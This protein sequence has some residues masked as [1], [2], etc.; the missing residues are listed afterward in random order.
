[1]SLCKA[2]VKSTGRTCSNKAVLNSDF[3]G[4]HKNRTSLDDLPP[5]IFDIIGRSLDV[6]D[7][8]NLKKVNKTIAYNSSVIKSIVPLFT[9]G[10]QNKDYLFELLADKMVTVKKLVIKDF[11]VTLFR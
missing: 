8:F 11:S 2:E 4:V 10:S 7:V 3:C 6:R 9:L 1:M 5:E